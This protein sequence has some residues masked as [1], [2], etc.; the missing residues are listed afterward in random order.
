[1]RSREVNF[2]SNLRRRDSSLIISSG[3]GLDGNDIHDF[4]TAYVDLYF[5]CRRN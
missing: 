5:G 4:G 2:F 3:T 1:M